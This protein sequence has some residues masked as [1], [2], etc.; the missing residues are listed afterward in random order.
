[1]THRFRDFL[2]LEEGQLLTFDYP[3]SQPID[4]LVNGSEKFNAHVVSTGKKRGCVIEEIHVH[5]VQGKPH[6]ELRSA[7]TPLALTS[8]G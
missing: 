1:M 5:P 8:A 7:E 6:S 4:V 2:A 3:I